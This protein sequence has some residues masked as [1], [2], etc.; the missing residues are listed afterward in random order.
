MSA[1]CSLIQVKDEPDVKWPF[2][3]GALYTL[4]MAG[5]LKLKEYEIF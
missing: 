5:K 2:E 1:N 4:V 3:S